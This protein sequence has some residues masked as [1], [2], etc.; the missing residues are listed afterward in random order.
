MSRFGGRAGVLFAIMGL[1]SPG[2]APVAAALVDL[3]HG[4]FEHMI[5]LSGVV[6]LAGAVFDCAARIV[7]HRKILAIF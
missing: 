1:A 2:G 7:S 5:I 4:R 3:V 6:V